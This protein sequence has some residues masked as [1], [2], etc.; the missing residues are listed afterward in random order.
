MGSDWKATIRGYVEQ[1]ITDPAN[2]ADAAAKVV[3]FLASSGLLRR[4]IDSSEVFR[5]EVDWIVRFDRGGK[6]YTYR[7]TL[8]DMTRELASRRAMGRD[9]PYSVHAWT[10]HDWREVKV[11]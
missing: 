5:G 1:L 8:E 6:V 4:P 9:K 11:S 7:R 3:Q 2:P 10:G